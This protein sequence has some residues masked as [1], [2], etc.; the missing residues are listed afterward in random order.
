MN[1]IKYACSLNNQGVDFLVS[2]QSARAIR[3]FQSAVGLLE[4]A[5]NDAERTAYTVMEVSIQE[6]TQPFCESVST[7]PGLQD[8]H[9]YVYDHGI[10]I[11]DTSNGESE[12]MLA[13]YTAIVLFNW[14][15]TS[16]RQGILGSETSSKKASLLYSLAEKLLSRCTI[17]E[18]T[19]T[20][21]LTLL[22]LNNKAQIHYDQCE[23]VQSVDCMKAILEIMGSVQGL[24]STL[25]N[26]DLE[27]ILLNVILLNEPT[28]AQAA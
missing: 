28:A 5:V 19:P 15:L 17:L 4:K 22:A 1:S 18:N 6:T 2:G 27:G 13:L 24:Y 25:G 8:I 21:I 7:V 16:H 11:T 12:E 9:C 20:T 23:Y 14:A 10:I 26:D 3:A